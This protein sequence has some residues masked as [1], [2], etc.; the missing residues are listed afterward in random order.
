MGVCWV[1]PSASTGVE[2]AYLARDLAK[3]QADVVRHRGQRAVVQIVGAAAVHKDLRCALGV[4]ER[5]GVCDR[6]VDTLHR[7]P[8]GLRAK[9][10]L[11]QALKRLAQTGHNEESASA[12]R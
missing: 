1:V 4:V 10:H 9:G 12:G 2:R 8:L 6:P 7:H 3:L 11:A 5:R